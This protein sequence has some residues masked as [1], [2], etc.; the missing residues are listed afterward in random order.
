MVQDAAQGYHWDNSQATL[1]PFVAYYRD[2]DGK[3][4]HSSM[5]VVSDCLPHSTIAVHRFQHEILQQVKQLCSS[6]RKIFYFSDG[7]ASQDKNYKNFCNLV[8]HID[9]FGIDAEWHFFATS[10]GKNA[11][12]TMKREA[13][14]ASLQAV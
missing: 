2:K 14:K 4:C 1:H 3:L 6:V 7:A 12:D 8:Y 5:C 11:C 9:D 10:H 13:A